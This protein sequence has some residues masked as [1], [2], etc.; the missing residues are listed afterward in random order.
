MASPPQRQPRSQSS[1]TRQDQGC[2]RRLRLP[3]LRSRRI[4]TAG[5]HR[6]TARRKKGNHCNRFRESSQSVLLRPRYRSHHPPGHRQR[7]LLSGGRFRESSPRRATSAS[8]P[9]THHAT[10]EKKQ[11]ATTESS[12]K[13]SSTPAPGR[14]RSNAPMPSASGTFTTTTTGHTQQPETNHQHRN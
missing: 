3:P 12:P 8:H 2:P 10:T 13:N 14:Q 11:S 6:S 5:L 4:L 7:R 1:R 9:R